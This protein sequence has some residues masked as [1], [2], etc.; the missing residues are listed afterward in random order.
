VKL[1]LN[2][3]KTRRNLYSRSTLNWKILNSVCLIPETEI[4]Y[5]VTYDTLFSSNHSCGLLEHFE[6]RRNTLTIVSWGV[7]VRTVSG[8]L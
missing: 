3:C 1:Q 7:S 5:Y 8:C 6:H 2:Q 4:F